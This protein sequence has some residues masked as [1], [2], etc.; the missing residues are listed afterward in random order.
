MS[1]C[2]IDNLN[3][4]K[5]LSAKAQHI[6][7]HDVSAAHQA[8]VFKNLM[9]DAIECG[10]SSAQEFYECLR[11]FE[12]EILQ[13][14]LD[15]GER[16]KTAKGKWLYTKT[17]NTSTYRSNKAVIGK[18]LDAGIPLVDGKVIRGKT[19]LEKLRREKTTTIM[20][21]YEKAK[22]G[23][24]MIQNVW[25]DLREDQKDSIVLLLGRDFPCSTG[26]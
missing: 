16:V 22:R 18:S 10:A 20:S 2:I 19:A 9:Q 26:R 15:N 5:G 6:A 11:P 4:F 1:N 23:V 14:R 25:E 8:D 13:I 21:P 17:T 12:E 3:N 7:Q 24:A